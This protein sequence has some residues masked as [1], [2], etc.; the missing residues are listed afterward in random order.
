MSKMT[1]KRFIVILVSVCA[2]TAALTYIFL[3]AVGASA[4]ARKE[5]RY[6][7]PDYIRYAAQGYSFDSVTN[8]TNILLTV[9]D[10]SSPVRIHLFTIDEDKQTL[11]ILDIPPFCYTVADGFSGT[12]ISAYDT[13]VYRQIVSQTLALKIDYQFDMSAD[14]LSTVCE[15]LGE[16]NAYL[17]KSLTAIELSFK[18]GNVT[19]D[20]AVANKIILLPDAY[21]NE[22]SVYIY[23][24]FLSSIINKLGDLGTIESVSKLTS[25]LLNSVDTDMSVS[26]MIELASASSKVKF[27]KINIHLLP[28]EMCEYNG[29]TVYSAHIDD[30]AELL[31]KSF[32][33]KGGEISADNLGAKEI[34]NSG[35]N[36]NLPKQISQY[37][38]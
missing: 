4:R 33:I 27:K 23:H 26:D 3:S 2:I 24:A 12:L 13:G 1:K 37:I 20:E 25:L 38:K 16:T 35:V 9:T 18:K 17:K 14:S 22:D 10:S 5:A 15:L 29:E 28:G 30:T 8:K 11:D 6:T 31:N 21:S 7:E 36:Y 19:F 34:V 32:R